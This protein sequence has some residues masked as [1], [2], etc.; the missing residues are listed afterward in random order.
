MPERQGAPLCFSTTGGSLSLPAMLNMAVDIPIPKWS[1]R[2]STKSGPGSAS[3]PRRALCTVDPR[4]IVSIAVASQRGSFVPVDRDM[5]PKMNSIVWSDRRA[6]REAR[7][8]ED[9]LGGVNYERIA[10]TRVSPIWTC[11]KI[12]W[13]ARERPDL[14][15]G[16][17][18]IVNDQEWIL[19][20][21]GADLIA[22]EAS[23]ATMNG[24]LDIALL[25]WSD[26][27][28]GACG[29]SRDLVLPIVPAMTA[30][31]YISAAAS[32]ATGFPRGKPL[33]YGGGD[34]Q[35][36]AVGAGVVSEGDCELTIGTGSVALC[37]ISAPISSTRDCIIQGAHVVARPSLPR[38]DIA[39]ERR[40][41]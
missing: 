14:L 36:A 27:I 2:T 25:D 29:I 12:L 26:K 40:F 4:S 8:L 1:S 10:G 39:L 9:A 38:G 6:G 5:R 17:W 13:L 23:S 20:N 21:L 15:A 3:P 41:S 33:F 11:S 32:E 28:L 18:K 22:T 24:M 34:Q 16:T 30:A 35:C 31:G 37:P 7:V 19:H